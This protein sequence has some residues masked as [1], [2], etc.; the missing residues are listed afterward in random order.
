MYHECV[1]LCVC[2]H[3]SYGDPALTM[4]AGL[5]LREC[6]R[7]RCIHDRI[8][9]DDQLIEPLFTKYIY[10]SNFDISS[11]AFQTIRELLR[12][13]RQLVSVRLKPQGE[14]YTRLFGWYRVLLQSSSY[15]INRVMIKLLAEFM[16]D[17]INFDIMIAFVGDADNLKLIMNLLCSPYESI[18]FDA[19]NVFKVSH[20]WIASP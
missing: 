9:C 2:V 8:L 15:M 20:R 14:L 18:Q 5:M 12:T 1:P 19:F 13:N 10:N 6:I 17:K 3:A 7:I 4:N 11:D 16:L